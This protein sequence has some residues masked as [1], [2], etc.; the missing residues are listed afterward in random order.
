MGFDVKF[1][2]S[3]DVTDWWP[4]LLTISAGSRCVIVQLH[5]SCVIP[6]SLLNLLSDACFVG[7][8]VRHKLSA[9]KREYGIEFKNVLDLQPVVDIAELSGCLKFEPKP[10]NIAMSNWGAQNLNID[11]I[12]TAA[13]D[14]FSFFQMANKLWCF[15]LALQDLA[16]I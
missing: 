13:T 11:Q 15:C 3:D 10:L 9:L 16:S 6:Q 14:A 4:A 2:R 8:E 7:I 5:R 1:A 12:Q